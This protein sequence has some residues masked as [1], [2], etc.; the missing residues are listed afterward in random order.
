MTTALSM[1]LALAMILFGA[2]LFTNSV[3]WFGYKL[4]LGEGAVGSVLAAL[5]TALPET[6]VPVTAI[7]SAHGSP[8]AHEV[9][10]GGILGAPFLL[11]T[12]GSLI[13]AISIVLFRRHSDDAAFVAVQHK[14]Y[15]RDM[16]FFLVAYAASIAVGCIP[17]APVHRV[18]PYVLIGIYGL[19]V[20]VNLRDRATGSAV[21]DLQPLYLQW[22]AKHDPSM[23]MIALQLLCSLA[24]IVGGAQLLSSGVEV[25]AVRLN[26]PAFVLSAILI[27]LATEL[28]ETLNSV[29]WLGQGK[30]ALAIGNVTGAMVFQST[31]VPALGISLTP[32]NLTGDALLTGGLTLTAGA[33]TFG[34]YQ[35][36]GRLS[37]GILVA[38]SLLYWVLPLQT[39]AARY[40][41]SE[42]YW[43]GGGT[44]VVLFIWS[45]RRG[46]RLSGI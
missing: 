35:L 8:S 16:T 22:K 17:L 15:Q 11:V 38:A 39:L 32:W 1:L 40:A 43:F 27:P 2:E 19:F 28:P 31:L 7:L 29:V 36:Y 42:L 4:H 24:A 9:G 33:L 5:G 30:D 14:A 37:P 45:L 20:V 12:L 26:I 44:L 41:L 21:H 34:L 25:L 6:A 23:P 13:V 3:E 46:V 18:A 10:I